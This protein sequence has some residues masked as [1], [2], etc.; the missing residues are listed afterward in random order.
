MLVPQMRAED[1]LDGASN[2]SSWKTRIIFVMEDLELWDIVQA[3]V[4]IPPITAPLLVEEFGKRN[5]N[6]SLNY[7]P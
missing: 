5:N 6:G 4:V 2:W 3:P 7:I 1:R